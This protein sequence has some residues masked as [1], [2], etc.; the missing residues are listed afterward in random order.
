MSTAKTGAIERLTTST[1]SRTIPERGDER[2]VP[3]IASTHRWTSSRYVRRSS[4]PSVSRMTLTSTSI[5]RRIS[6]W[7]RGSG[8]SSSSSPRRFEDHERHRLPAVMGDADVHGAAVAPLRPLHRLSVKMHHGFS[9]SPPN[10]LDFMPQDPLGFSG[11]ER[12]HHRFLHREAAR[13]ALRA[14]RAAHGVGHFRVREYPAQEPFPV[15]VHQRLDARNIDD[16][17]PDPGD[18]IFPILKP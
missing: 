6:C 10:R 3:R 16:V 11:S 12:L 5:R 17:H 1:T 4:T 7:A 2:P 15:P 13:E 8:A 14:V 18:H 9:E